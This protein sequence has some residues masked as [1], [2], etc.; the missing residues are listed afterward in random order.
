MAGIRWGV[1]RCPECGAMSPVD[2]ISV[3]VDYRDDFPPARLGW[4][5]VLVCPVH[6]TFEAGVDF[7]IREVAAC[8]S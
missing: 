6:G 2:K 5:T 1:G 8:P 7:D 3:E 4:E